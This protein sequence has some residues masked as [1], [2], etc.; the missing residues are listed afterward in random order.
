MHED[1][2][3][4]STCAE[5][6]KVLR[7]ITASCPQTAAN[8][9]SKH[10]RKCGHGGPRCA[11]KGGD[12]IE[13]RGQQRRPKGLGAGGVQVRYARTRRIDIDAHLGTAGDTVQDEAEGK[14]GQPVYAVLFVLRKKK[15][16]QGDGG[17][18]GGQDTGPRGDGHIERIACESRACAS[19]GV[20]GREHGCSIIA[21]DR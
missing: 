11:T 3:Q 14:E 18:S 21:G 4:N 7:L 2:G 10:K 17:R 15:A 12:R 1:H 19:C 8:V 6:A 5:R 16:Q 20:K 13:A 9:P